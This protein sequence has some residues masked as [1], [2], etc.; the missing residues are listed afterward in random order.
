MYE[1]IMAR[2][3]DINVRKSYQKCLQT[4]SFE[5]WMGEQI[6]H[7][8]LT[9]YYLTISNMAILNVV[10]LKVSLNLNRQITQIISKNST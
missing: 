4:P 8:I 10:I 3:R 5:S 7:S 6:K 9:L 1:G 2:L